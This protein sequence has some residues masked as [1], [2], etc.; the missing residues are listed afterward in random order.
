MTTPTLVLIDIQNDY[1]AGGAKPLVGPDAA[2]AAAARVLQTFRDND[3]PRVHIRHEA[4]HA[5]ATFLRKGTPGSEIHPLVAP[6]ANELVVSKRFPDAFQGTDLERTLTG[7]GTRELVIAGMMTHICI[8]T[9]VRSAFA[10]GF[11]VT[12]IT[13]ATASCDLTYGDCR[14]PAADVQTAF[15]AALDGLFANTCLADDWSRLSATA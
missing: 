6:T 2:A 11:R 14:V 7:L 5:G 13:D 10:K 8:D 9:S 12:L 15:L 3:W 1:F 4:V